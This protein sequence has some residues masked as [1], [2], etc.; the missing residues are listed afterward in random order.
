[1]FRKILVPTD[2]SVH[3]EKAERLGVDIALKYDAE[4]VF[5]SVIEGGALTPAGWQLAR[6]K[7]LDV[8]V[9]V[10]TPQMAVQSPEGAPVVPGSEHT[11]AASRVH[12][13][14]AERLV[15]DAKTQAETAGVRKVGG[16]TRDGK[17]VD[18]I[19]EAAAD[20]NVDVIVMGSRGLGSLKGLLVG[21]V[22]TKVS[23]P[24]G[25]P[26]SASSSPIA[27]YG[28][29]GRTAPRPR[30]SRGRRL[31]LLCRGRRAL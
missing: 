6:E 10:G 18:A 25:V 15:R 21:S 16:L 11:L 19:L 4:L 12:A 29:R 5:L 31:I 20:E 3:A 26:A 22:S 14:L 30:G 27:C 1:M 7:G 13:E 24:P 23:H 17:V 2:G 8:G 9:L 28:K